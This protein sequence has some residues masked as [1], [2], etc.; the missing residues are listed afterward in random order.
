MELGAEGKKGFLRILRLAGIP[1]GGK[2]AT[3][4]QRGEP[5]KAG[6]KVLIAWER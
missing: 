3:V 6:K 5:S 4:V 1:P 2:D